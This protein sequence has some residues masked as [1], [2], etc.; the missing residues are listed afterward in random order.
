MSLPH[1][2]LAALLER[3]GSGSE[4][5]SRFDRSIGYFWH[6]T[7]Q[8]IYRELARLEK[9]GLLESLPPESGRGRKRAYR[10]LPAGRAELARWTASAV[11]L[12]PSRNELMVR[13]RAEA[14]V[15]PTGLHEELERHLRLHEAKLALYEQIQQRDFANRE[16]TRGQR[17]QALVLRSGIESETQAVKFC[18]DALAV[19]AEDD[20][21]VDTAPR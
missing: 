9:A 13:I 14:I 4:L 8:Q 6:A 21:R 17:L 20:E 18:R 7:H 5:A 12:A 1:A 10:V 3:P 11:D 15:G 16:L 19:L 2:L